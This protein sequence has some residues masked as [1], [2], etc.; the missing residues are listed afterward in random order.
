M[1][2]QSSIGT[3]GRGGEALRQHAVNSLRARRFFD[4]FDPM[5]WAAFAL[6]LPVL[7]VSL[8]RYETKIV[9]LNIQK[10]RQVLWLTSAMGAL[11]WYGIHLARAQDLNELVVALLAPAFVTGGAW[12][13]VTFGGVQEK[14]LVAAIGLTKWMFA[15]FSISL[16]TMFIALN[17]ILPWPLTVVIGVIIVLVLLSA[18]T[19]DNVDSLKIGL[20][21][22]LRRHSLTMLAKLGAEGIPTMDSDEQLQLFVEEQVAKRNE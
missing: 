18:V 17:Q 3:A 5:Y 10:H 11:A 6:C 1:R 8:N 20:D 19:Y 7:I 21:D 9:E 15:A 16:V 13:A 4:I 2:S 12:F 14:L 22:A